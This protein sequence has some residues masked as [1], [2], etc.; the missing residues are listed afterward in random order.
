MLALSLLLNNFLNSCLNIFLYCVSLHSLVNE[1]F[2]GEEVVFCNNEEFDLEP[3]APYKSFTCKY[4]ITLCIYEALFSILS[5][6]HAEADTFLHGT[7]TEQEM[8]QTCQVKAVGLV[9][10][11]CHQ[12][13]NR[14]TTGYLFYFNSI[15]FIANRNSSKVLQKNIL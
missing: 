14:L 15:G 4:M 9:R 10:C 12:T 1:R 8:G 6:Y 7:D 13:K 2:G 5:F 3:V 11:L